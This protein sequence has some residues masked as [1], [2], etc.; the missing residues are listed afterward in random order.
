MSSSILLERSLEGCQLVFHL[1]AQNTT[2]ISVFEKCT[3]FMN[4]VKST[5][6]LLDAMRRSNVSKIIFFSS[7]LVYGPSNGTAKLSEENAALFPDTQY[8]ASKLAC[9]A[10]L[11]SFSHNCGIDVVIIRLSNIISHDFGRGVIY[12]LVN[13]ISSDGNKLEILGDGR[14]ERSYLLMEDL[15]R[16]LHILEEYLLNHRGVYEIFNVGNINTISVLEIAGI[17]IQC[18]KLQGKIN[19]CPLEQESNKISKLDLD[20]SKMKIL[21]WSPTYDSGDT[22]RMTINSMI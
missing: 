4:N 10:L 3:D 17:L 12:D 21:G 18:K 11:S 15:I 8:G 16:A 5:Y 14:Q 7:Q 13:R 6:N 2:R 19:I 20:I 9:E 22:V 1:A